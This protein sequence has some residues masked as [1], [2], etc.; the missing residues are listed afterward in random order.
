MSKIK[1]KNIG[2]NQTEMTLNGKT[3][4]YSYK[5][6]VVVQTDWVKTN[7]TVT[8]EKIYITSKKF[9]KTTSKHINKYVK[10]LPSKWERIIVSQEELEKM[11]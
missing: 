6:P 8:L 11:I 10:D 2:S 5:T 9:S 7:D 4:F 3:I 1:L